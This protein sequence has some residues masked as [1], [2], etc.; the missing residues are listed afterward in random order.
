MGEKFWW[1]Y[2]ILSAAVIIFFIY[3]SA[4]K[5]FSKILIKVAGCVVSIILALVISKQTAGFVYD[6]FIKETS[7]NAVEEAMD[8]YDPSPAIK[9]II[10]DQGYGAVADEGRIKDIIKS[11]AGLNGLYKYANN[12]AGDKVDVFEKF[13][14][15]MTGEFSKKFGEQIGIKLPPYV[16]GAINDK[17]SGNQELFEETLELIV[18][19]PDK[20]P[21]F[22][23]KNFIRGPGEKLSQ[24][25]SFLILFAVFM[26]VI[27]F[28]A[29]KTSAFGLLNGY[30]RLDKF[31]GGV[32][33]IA[34]AA[35]AMFAMAV[36]VKIMIDVAES[37]GSFF[38]YETVDKTYIFKHFFEKV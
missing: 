7:M 34:R 10:E 14:D 8:E 16:T 38:S 19:S 4:K 29:V 36:I 26:A 21:E 6:K 27:G 3:R 13:S 28:V 31:F 9:K 11:G 17:I 1:I 35:V 33:G 15:F 32:L 5:G 24:V 23:E 20:M 25:F 18:L 2:D 37:S 22:V 12:S 30:D